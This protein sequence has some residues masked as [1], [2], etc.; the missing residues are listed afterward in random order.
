MQNIKAHLFSI[1]LL[2][3]LLLLFTATLFYP[4]GSQYSATSIGYSWQHNYLSNLFSEVAMNGAPNTAR[5]WATIGMLF[6]CSSFALF[7]W[8]FSSKITDKNASKI[9]KYSGAF[10]MLIAFGAA[11]PL[12]DTAITIAGVL[13]LL[14]IFY[15]SV[16]VFK[17]RLLLL[18]FISAAVLILS[19]LCNVVYYLRI[20][21]ET[22]P[23][24]QKIA[25][26]F[27]ICWMLLLKYQSTSKDF[28]PIDMTKGA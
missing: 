12:H 13:S 8:E 15:V 16:F 1:L 17:S 28:L 3:A 26:A 21:V 7:F 24:L 10:G 9:I 2:I 22:L 20:Y 19:Y 23:V 4:G 25:L 6:F 5:V 14:S 27:I 11:T 18:K